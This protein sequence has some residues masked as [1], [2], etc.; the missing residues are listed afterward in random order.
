MPT[1]DL[2]GSRVSRY[3]WG[4]CALLFFATTINYIDRQVLGLLAPQLRGEFGWTFE[5]YG[6]IASA[7]TLAYAI[8]FLVA[9]WFIDRVGT[10]VGFTVY[11]IFWSIA[12]ASHAFAGSIRG[13]F[14]ARFALGLGES[15]NFPASV[16][17]VAEWFPK[18]ERALAIGIF[19]AGT[20]VG[21]F[22]APFI[23][24][25]ALTHLG[26]QEA[27]IIT[28]LGGLVWVAFW[29][30]IYHRPAEHPKISA[31]ELALIQSDPPDPVVKLPWRKLLTFRQTWAFAAGKFLTDSVWWFY[32]GWFPLFMNDR[33]G[34]DL[35]GIT[36]MVA[37]VYLL[38]DFGSVGGGWLS[39]HLLKRGWS[40]NAARKTALIVCASFI[41]P[42][43]FAPHVSGAW[44]AV[45]LIGTAMAAHQGFS[46][47]LFTLTS[48]MFPRSMVA[49]VVG[50]GGFCGAMGG[51]IMN[52]SAGSIRDNTGSFESVFILAGLAYFTA[53]L[54]IHLF[55]P[56]LE[57]ANVEAV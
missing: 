44:T 17:T 47:N 46:A 27:F 9:G 49:S 3:R 51:Y 16:K 7:F 34:V 23:V 40:T 48:D 33:F 50:I 41:V 35:W 54:V 37:T 32:L 5:E 21:A 55:A 45:W 15:G 56:R 19:N 30:P 57:P 38:A 43:M 1:T 42:V 4:I 24:A 12:A 29:W 22:V 52:L 8:G 36:I 11:L 53:I 28:G 6:S 25:L 18:R 20:N 14:T 26:W 2:D 31:G 10:R 13:F 39:S